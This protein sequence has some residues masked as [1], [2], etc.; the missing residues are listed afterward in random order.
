MINLTHGD[1]GSLC[2]AVC[3][4]A[5]C[6]KGDERCI[7]HNKYGVY[8]TRDEYAER[9]LDEGWAVTYGGKQ[10]I[11]VLCPTCTEREK[12]RYETETPH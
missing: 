11:R 2:Q 3:D 9:L 4:A 5:N 8:I 1:A 12:K 6:G 7:P 10:I